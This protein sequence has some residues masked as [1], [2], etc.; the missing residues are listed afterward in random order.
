MIEQYDSMGGEVDMKVL[1]QL[2]IASIPSQPN[3]SQI[4]ASYSHQSW[5]RH[6]GILERKHIMTYSN[7]SRKY[8][9]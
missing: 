5:I 6:D 9:H 4:Q 8:V 3:H 2:N 1:P 7:T